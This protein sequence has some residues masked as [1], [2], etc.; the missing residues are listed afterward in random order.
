MQSWCACAGDAVWA[1]RISTWVNTP[2]L[3]RSSWE[4][5]IFFF[6]LPHGIY[7]FTSYF[8][9]QID[10]QTYLE[11]TAFLLLVFLVQF[12]GLGRVSFTPLQHPLLQQL[13]V[14]K[15]HNNSLILLS[16]NWLHHRTQASCDCWAGSRVSPAC[17]QCPSCSVGATM[18]G[19]LRWPFLCALQ[20]FCL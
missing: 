12:W 8:F 15:N 4:I 18:A 6:F 10:S 9:P 11:R 14:P 20:G 1:G 5:F 3:M 7:L 2:P 13:L 19:M 16:A 17:P